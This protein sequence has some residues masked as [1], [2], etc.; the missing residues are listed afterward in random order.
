MFTINYSTGL[1]R[2]QKTK[3]TLK[4]F[5]F[6]IGACGLIKLNRVGNIYGPQSEK[7]CLQHLQTTKAQTDQ[8]LCYSLF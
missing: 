2:N 5:Y 1:N 4:V 3:L 6:F 8:R 7:I